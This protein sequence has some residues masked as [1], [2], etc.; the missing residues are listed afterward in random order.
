[1]VFVGPFQCTRVASAKQSRAE[2]SKAKPTKG[3]LQLAA[4][5]RALTGPVPCLSEALHLFSPASRPSTV[6][7]LY[8]VGSGPR[9]GSSSSLERDMPCRE[10]SEINSGRRQQKQ[11]ISVAIIRRNDAG[12]CRRL[13]C[14]SSVR[15]MPI[16][17]KLR[18]TLIPW[19][20]RRC[21]TV[22][23]NIN[24]MKNEGHGPDKRLLKHCRHFVAFCSG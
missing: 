17:R 15:H 24:K 8:R 1:M 10:N 20:Y 2:Q 6:V 23:R 18:S 12:R 7:A 14:Y 5:V 3:D 21:R 9:E 13:C 16:D 11:R 4:A 22:A 19:Q